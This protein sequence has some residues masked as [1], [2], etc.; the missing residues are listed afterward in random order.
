LRSADGVPV[1]GGEHGDRAA[2]LFDLE[3]PVHAT[4]LVEQVFRV[5]EL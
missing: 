2:E 4:G 3:T 5:R 1:A